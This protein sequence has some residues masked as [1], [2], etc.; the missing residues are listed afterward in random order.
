MKALSWLLLS[1]VLCLGVT[2]LTVLIFFLVLRRGTQSL[3]QRVREAAEAAQTAETS[4]TG[5]RWARA[6]LAE[7]TE[8]DSVIEMAACPACGGENLAGS[9]TC[10]FCGRKL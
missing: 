2:V 5:T 6:G 4:G 3:N 9:D 8:P 7:K 1:P 10:A